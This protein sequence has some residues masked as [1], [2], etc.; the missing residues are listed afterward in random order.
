VAL[1][2][3]LRLQDLEDE[4][5]LTEAAGSSDVEAAGQ[6]GQLGDIVLF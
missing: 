2:F 3:A 6:L 4:I 5:L 1:F